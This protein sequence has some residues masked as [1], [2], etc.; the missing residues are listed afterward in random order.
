MAARRVTAVLLP[1]IA[2]ALLLAGC[3]TY[4]NLTAYFNTY[5]NA[6]Q[7]FDQAVEELLK[8]PQPARDSNYF[9]PYRLTSALT[10]KFEKVIEKGS[11]IIQFHGESGYVED[12]I[13]LIGKSYLYQNE[14]ESAAGKFRELLENFPG[15]GKRH[16]ARLWLARALYQGK[17]TDEALAIARETAAGMVG[18]GEE[19][20]TPG[21]ILLEMTMLEAQIHSDRGDF[22]QA[23][24]ALARAVD[25][26][27]GGELKAVARYQL[28]TLHER[29]GDYVPA[30][31]A[32]RSVLDHGPTPAM[33]FNARLRQGVMLSMSGRP[34]EALE[35]FDEI[36]SWPLRPEQSAL[37]DLEI[38]NAYWN[39]GDSAAAFTLYEIVD[40]TYKRTDAA[41]RSYYRR[42]EI[43]EKDYRKL[44]EARKFY[45]KAKGEHAA[46]AVTQPAAARFTS[47]DHY[48]RT[49]QRLAA[50]DS[51]LR[52]LLRRDSLGLA[53]DSAAPGGTA[54]DSARVDSTATA[55]A[56]TELAGPADE[57][58]REAGGR[59]EPPARTGLPPP[60][61]RAP[62]LLTS[63]NL[64]MRQI[65]SRP[66][67]LVP[68]PEDPDDPLLAEADD[69][70]P[71]RPED[72]LAGT[73]GGKGGGAGAAPPSG[74]QAKPVPRT[75]LTPEALSA[76]IA[77]SRYEL[78]GI[79]LLDLNLPD[80]ALH[81]YELLVA[82]QPESP[83]V[84][85]T[86][87]A[88]SEARRV[89]GDSAAVDSLQEV[90]LT[91]HGETEYADQVRK[92][93]GL[94]TTAVRESDDA[95][96]Y[97]A[98][99]EA[100]FGGDSTAA[101]AAFR[102]LADSSG[103]STVTPKAVYAVGWI[104]ENI[105]LDLDSA[106]SWYKRVLRD[107]PSS[108]YAAGVE[109]RVA[110][111][112]D[113]SKLKQ[114]VKIKEIQP[115]PKPQKKL[116][117]KIAT[118]AQQPAGTLPPAGADPTKLPPGAVDDDEYYDPGP[119]EDEE[120]DP[121][122]GEEDSDD[123][124]D[125]DDDPGRTAALPDAANDQPGPA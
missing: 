14:T 62:A 117:T 123:F 98:A 97:R 67:H 78:G 40:S 51:T 77:E 84:P 60:Q 125:E 29:T 104:Y 88:M 114:Y 18:G 52:G 85:K 87:Y 49:H 43:L 30:A 96:R 33:R 34:E 53:G 81:Y 107:H 92:F 38:A 112:G 122:D 91:D 95:L 54:A 20:E 23:A 120:E 111:R 74:Q 93:R 69:A 46:S 103:D 10:G 70:T 83:L 73:P 79:L 8:T 89:L 37:V 76:R 65:R 50:D 113:S 68:D 109:A 116:T 36:I 22:A 90:L 12:A 42:G 64:S 11:R 39:R 121:D 75:T 41:A 71:G 15:S 106:E 94:D 82:E 55:V 26:D 7:L 63:E 27:A 9:A 16:E 3:G 6:S 110:V 61:R 31:E 5:Y 4:R 99:E 105:L 25:A 13:M 119:D 47:L 24:A 32:Y 35:T 56:S 1:A 101:L 17:D 86:L 58:G 102:S 21:D 44:A 100:L 45:E 19:G 57:D 66:R 59:A 124:Q 72:A 108:A 115:I 80:S 28:G 2:G 48:V 118:G